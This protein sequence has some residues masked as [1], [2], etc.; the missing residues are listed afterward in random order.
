MPAFLM[1]YEFYLR[2]SNS[3]NIKVEI[4]YLDNAEYMLPCIEKYS[5][6]KILIFVILSMTRCL[7]LGWYGGW[8]A[9]YMYIRTAMLC[10]YGWGILYNT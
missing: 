9:G 10:F 4:L 3:L 5:H 8:L 7:V 6:W 1:N 2:R